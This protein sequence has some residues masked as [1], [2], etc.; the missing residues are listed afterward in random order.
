MQCKVACMF[1][2]QIITKS[3]FMNMQQIRANVMSVRIQKVI[4]THEWQKNLCATRVA[5]TAN[6]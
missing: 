6:T 2:N 3:S 5:K 1:G 4:D